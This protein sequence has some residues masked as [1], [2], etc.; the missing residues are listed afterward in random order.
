MYGC[1]ERTGDGRSWRDQF[2]PLVGDSPAVV[3]AAVLSPAVAAA[4]AVIRPP[5]RESVSLIT[6]VTAI[7]VAKAIVAASAL[8]AV[9][10]F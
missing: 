6:L 2:Q 10:I 1:R 4:A 5:A 8:V 3:A 9:K 7:L